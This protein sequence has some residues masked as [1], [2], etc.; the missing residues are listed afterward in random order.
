MDGSQPET[1]SELVLGFTSDGTGGTRPATSHG[2]QILV[3]VVVSMTTQPESITVAYHVEFNVVKDNGELLPFVVGR[4]D[5]VAYV[6]GDDG[7]FHHDQT[8]STVAKQPVEI[9]TTLT[10]AD[11]SAEFLKTFDGKREAIAAG[12]DKER[13]H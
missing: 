5:R 11:F 13:I 2:G 12:T 6:R 10:D 8:L 7:N 4:N 9:S 3:G 1:N